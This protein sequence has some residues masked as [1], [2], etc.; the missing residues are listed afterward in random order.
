MSTDLDAQPAAAS[1]TFALGGDLPVHRLGYGAMQLTGPGVW[2]DPKDPDEAVRVLRRAVELG[3]N[4]IDT[5]DSYGPFVSEQL[6]RKALHPYP[7]GLVIATKAGLTRQGPN[8]WRPVGRPE[9]LRQQAELSLRHLGVDRIDLYQL[10]RIDPQVPLADQLGEL[11]ALQQEGKIRHIGVS[12]VTVE[13]LRAARELAT[14]VSVQ[15]L[16]NLANRADEDV[17]NYAEQENIGFIPWFPIATGELAAP[18]GPLAAIS[19]EHGATPAQLALAW[20]L[21]R[22]RV[23]LPIPG[24]S[25]VAHVEEN[26]AAARIELTDKEFEALSAA[27]GSAGN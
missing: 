12:Q 22:S 1:G 20:L 21:R 17:L 27:T 2:G 11:V 14:I 8:E 9:Y 15:N 19:A 6:I 18:G 5:A 4:F 25:S 24:T 7:E 16:Y 13:Q 10:H 3:V 26:I 23:L